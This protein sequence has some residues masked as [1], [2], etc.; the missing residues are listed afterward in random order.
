[1]TIEDGPPQLS[2]EQVPPPPPMSRRARSHDHEG[3]GRE[4]HA[5]S[6]L[7]MCGAGGGMPDIEDFPPVAQRLSRHGGDASR[8]TRARAMTMG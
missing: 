7:P 8:E 1:M 6:C 3:R 5:R 4:I 2:L